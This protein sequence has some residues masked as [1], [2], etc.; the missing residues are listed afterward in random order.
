MAVP[1]I[2]ELKRWHTFSDDQIVIRDAPPG[3]SCPVVETMRGSDFVLLVTEPTPFGLHDLKLVAQLARELEIPTGVVLNRAGIGDS[4]VEEFCQDAGIPIM[5]RI[6]LDEAIGAAVARGNTLV[7]AFPEYLPQFRELH[8]QIT[9]LIHPEKTPA[10]IHTFDKR[11]S[12]EMGLG[13]S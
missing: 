10:S 12:R 5:M 6:P 2:R 4:N 11:V 3:T 7:E 1:I 8:T 9:S 13:T